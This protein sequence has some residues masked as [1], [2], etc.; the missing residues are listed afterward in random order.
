M[1]R[2]GCRSGVDDQRRLTI[3]FA[4]PTTYSYVNG[5]PV[6]KVDPTG[7]FGIPGF[8]GAAAFNFG[9][10]FM[11][12]LYMGDGDWKRALKCIDFG[13][14]AISGA[15]GFVG[16]SFLSNVL[17]GKAGPAGLSA[18]QN[19]FLYFT[20]SLPA[21]F[22]L[23]KGTPP[24]RVGDDCECEGLSLGNLLGAFAH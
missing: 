6:S 22:A 14:V 10:Q 9:T 21:G 3:N 18:A 16:P 2:L 19:R 20:Q 1:C 23:K 8:F 15:L 17:G 13:D 5:N 11:T 4:G 24:L 12:N 7:E